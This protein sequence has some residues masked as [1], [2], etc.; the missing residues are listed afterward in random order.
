MGAIMT[1]PKAPAADVWIDPDNA[2]GYARSAQLQQEFEAAAEHLR[3]VDGYIDPDDPEHS[4]QLRADL[5]LE[6]GGVKGI[7]LAG[8]VLALDEAGYSFARVAGTSA[9]AI[10][11]SLV[12]AIT[13]AG[14]PMTTLHTYLSQ[15]DFTKFMPEGKIHRF[16]DKLGGVMQ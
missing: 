8:A 13:K 5:A 14:Q 3:Q 12:V 16:L 1:T 4:R 11:A 6:G 7:G 9:G 2:R 15:V 10:A